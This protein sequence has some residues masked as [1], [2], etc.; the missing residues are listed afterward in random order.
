MAEVDVPMMKRIFLVCETDDFDTYV[1]GAF[2]TME[3]ATEFSD[4]LEKKQLEKM[5]IASGFSIQ[6]TELYD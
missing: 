5:G 6:E 1:R 3:K 2:L 4:G